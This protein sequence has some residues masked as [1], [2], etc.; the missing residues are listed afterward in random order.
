MVESQDPPKLC[1]CGLGECVLVERVGGNQN[2]FDGAG[3]ALYSPEGAGEVEGVFSLEG[4]GEDLVCEGGRTPQINR[5]IKKYCSPQ[6][7]RGNR[8]GNQEHRVVAYHSTPYGWESC[9][10]SQDEAEE[11]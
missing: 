7:V 4:A 10:G 1:E 6:R 3:E 11:S 2:S 5:E 8:R 9:K